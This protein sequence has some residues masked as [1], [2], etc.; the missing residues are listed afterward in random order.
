MKEEL[1][2]GLTQEQIAKVKACNNQDELL[3]IAKEEGVELTSEQLEA[4]SGGNCLNDID[5]PN[6]GQKIDGSSCDDYY[7]YTC[8]HCGHKF[9]RAKGVIS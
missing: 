2:H 3:R 8:P 1:L 6:C 7:N 9:R 5:C 4:V